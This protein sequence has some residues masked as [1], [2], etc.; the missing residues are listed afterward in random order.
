MAVVWLLGAVAFAWAFGGILVQLAIWI[1]ALTIQL[2]AWIF[3]AF[4]ILASLAWLALTDRPAL[5]R[6]W[7]D[8][9]PGRRLQPG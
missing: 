1:V 7:R 3:W 4:V 8:A 2:L 5:A 9:D 6:C